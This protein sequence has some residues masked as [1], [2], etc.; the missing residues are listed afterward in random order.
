LEVQ[1]E[2]GEEGGSFFSFFSSAGKGIVDGGLNV[3]ETV[4]KKTMQVINETD[5]GLNKTK[6]LLA[7]RKNKVNLSQMLRDAKK[8]REEDEKR[9][10]EFEQT[11]KTKFHYWFEEEQG[12]VYLEALEILSGDC[13]EE[14]ETRIRNSDPLKTDLLAIRDAFLE[15]KDR[16]EDDQAEDRAEEDPAESGAEDRT[17]AE[18]EEGVEAGK[19]G[20]F[21]DSIRLNV[22]RLGVR[23]TLAKVEKARLATDSAIAR[24][25]KM[26]LG[27]VFPE[28]EE[29]KEEE[30]EVQ[31][32][33]E[34]EQEQ[35]QE[36]EKE[37]AEDKNSI[38]DVSSSSPRRR[39][40]YTQKTLTVCHQ[41]AVETLGILV[42]AALQF[43]HKTNQ[44]LLM[45]PTPTKTTPVTTTP[46]N[47]GVESN[48]AA[49][50]AAADGTNDAAVVDAATGKLD[51]VLAKVEALFRLKTSF[52]GEVNRIAD[53]FARALSELE[54]V[55]TDEDGTVD[56]TVDPVI[57]GV[58]LEASHGAAF[59]EEAYNLSIPILQ[60]CYYD[61]ATA[62]RD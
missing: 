29:E 38:I 30:R 10:E 51:A 20:N 17:Q 26:A 23:L 4:G 31:E 5:P 27:N 11:Q 25:R 12:L 8:D 36:Q 16:A 52:I 56:P 24:V 45:T 53:E 33:K 49:V 34:Q 37:E 50:N 43:F 2:G 58:Y 61:E 60:K 15:A 3:L 40:S 42:A 39:Y 35:E 54:T 13:F 46:T 32:Q 28:E 22:E 14:L 7:D 41:A 9:K 1:P 57:T 21:M 48:D 18:T 62:G 6:S 47:G 19:K 59:V 55:S 44:T